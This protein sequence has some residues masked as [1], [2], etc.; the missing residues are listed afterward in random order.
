MFGSPG[1]IVNQGWTLR[2]TLA[3][4]LSRFLGAVL[5]PPRCCLCGLS[6]SPPDLD[7]CPWCL[8]ALPW[9]TPSH[10][11]PICAVRFERPVDVLVRELKYR[12]KT[13]HAPVLAELLSRAVRDAGRPL[14]HLLLPVPQHPARWRARG[15]NH[16]MVIT[17]HLARRLG[18]PYAN[19]LRRV[20]DTPSQTGLDRS[21]RPVNVRDAF[22][23]RAGS[24][25]SRLLAA[26]HVAVVDDV[27]TT[28]STLDE[29]RRVLLAAGLSRVDLWAVARA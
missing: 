15:L 13:E 22:E 29:I 18:V 26:G 17:R 8:E 12:A 7:L 16:A 3:R 21:Q 25:L 5:F 1:S 19:A 11:D 6:G 27:T 4:G 20:R 2:F 9:L 23:V 10:C 24:H 28:G 14:P